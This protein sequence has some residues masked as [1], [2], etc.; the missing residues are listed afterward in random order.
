MHHKV[1]GRADAWWQTRDNV[2]I[3][4]EELV[5]SLINQGRS[6]CPRVLL[7]TL[8][9]TLILLAK[10][11]YHSCGHFHI[12]VHCCCWWS[13]KG[14]HFFCVT[15]SQ[16]E[17]VFIKFRHFFCIELSRIREEEAAA[18]L[19]KS[20]SCSMYTRCTQR[21]CID[22]QTRHPSSGDLEI[23]IWMYYVIPRIWWNCD[24]R[25]HSW[26]LSLLVAPAH[27]QK[28]QAPWP[29]LSHFLSLLRGLQTL[30][31]KTRHKSF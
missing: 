6:S 15:C 19:F 17:C 2:S 26:C 14:H 22:H 10:C 23:R 21:V 24:K 9:C 3:I 18:A 28:E 11:Q 5:I 13:C 1:K 29:I 7:W 25:P 12:L 16:A 4:F 8:E 31:T 27:I 20:C 30:L